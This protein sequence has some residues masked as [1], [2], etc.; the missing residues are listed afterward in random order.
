MT[1]ALRYTTEIK[2]VILLVKKGFSRR[3]KV[4]CGQN[5]MSSKLFI[6]FVVLYDEIEEGWWHWRCEY[7]TD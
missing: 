6:R 3:R 7:G 1:K 5:I 2:I 4:L